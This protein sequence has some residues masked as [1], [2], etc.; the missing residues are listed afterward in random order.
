MKKKNIFLILAAI[1]VGAGAA[2]FMGSKKNHSCDT[3][4]DVAPAGD[5]VGDGG[6]GPEADDQDTD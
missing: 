4:D 6:P 5:G 1:A 3:I 2:I